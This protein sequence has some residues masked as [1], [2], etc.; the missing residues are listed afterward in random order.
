MIPKI[1]HDVLDHDMN[2]SNPQKSDD[3]LVFRLYGPQDWPGVRQLFDA[4]GPL[5]S[6]TD[7]ET[8]DFPFGEGTDIG[9]V[10]E[11]A[12]QIVGVI[13]LRERRGEVAHISHLREHPQWKNRDVALRLASIALRHAMEQQCL[14][15]VFYSVAHIGVAADFERAGLLPAGGHGRAGHKHLD[16]YLDLYRR[17][18][19]TNFPAD[20]QGRDLPTSGQA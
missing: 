10:A 15:I 9:W 20:Q 19:R 13:V 16:F 11:M 1:L 17:L 6:A 18:D 8:H 12:G 5:P 14:K 2:S 4:T 3:E 7:D